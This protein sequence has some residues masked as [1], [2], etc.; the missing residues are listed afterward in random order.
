MIVR[1]YNHLYFSGAAP[2]GGQDVPNLW[3]TDAT[4]NSHG[5][6]TPTL[7]ATGGV[8]GGLQPCSLTTGDL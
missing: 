7:V 5:E 4:L 1:A 3:Q 8:G 2:V 6:P